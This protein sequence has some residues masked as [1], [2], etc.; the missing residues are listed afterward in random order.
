MASEAIL[1]PRTI[2]FP[3]ITTKLDEKKKHSYIR[4]AKWSRKGE[5]DDGTV[6]RRSVVGREKYSRRFLTI[7]RIRN[8]W[9]FNNQRQDVVQHANSIHCTRVPANRAAGPQIQAWKP[10]VTLHIMR[11]ALFSNFVQ[12]MFSNGGNLNE[13]GV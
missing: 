5:A 8:L 6:Q 2:T 11:K 4:E 1:D 3:P 7:W 9:T 10:P 12:F 13:F